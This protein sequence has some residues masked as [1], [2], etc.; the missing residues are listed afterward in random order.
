V[1]NVIKIDIEGGE[2]LAL[3]G[4]RRILNEFH[5]EI[6]MELHGPEAA[7]I[8][9]QILSDADYKVLRMQPGYPIVTSVEELDWKAYLVAL[10]ED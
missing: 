10:H 7:K 9:W 4:M 6:L 5:P 3:R 8:C 2:T 1:P